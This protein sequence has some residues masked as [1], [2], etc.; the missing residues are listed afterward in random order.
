MS[1]SSTCWSMCAE[2]RYSSP[3]ASMGET[4]A[5]S[6]A[7]V[8]PAK[9][10]ACSAA[11]APR[12]IGAPHLE[13]AADV[14]EHE[15]G[16]RGEDGRVGQ[17]V[18]PRVLHRHGIVA[19]RCPRVADGPR[20]SAD[21]RGSAAS[22]SRGAGRSLRSAACW[23]GC[24]RRR[25]AGPAR[26]SRGAATRSAQAA[27]PSLHR[28]A[29]EPVIL[30]GVPVW[31][32]LAYSGPARDLVRALKFRGAI[33]LA[34]AM[35]AQIVANARAATVLDGRHAR[36]RPVT[37][38]PT[39]LARLQPGGGDRGRGRRPRGTAGARLPLPV[40]P[41]HHPG[42]PRPR[43]TEGRAGRCGSSVDGERPRAGAPRRRRRHDG[44]HSRAPAVTLSSR[45]VRERWWRC[46]SR[47]R[48][49]AEA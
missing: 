44:R 30:C 39:A 14:D 11:R 18:N 29:A 36:S 24:S 5:A 13:E 23:A 2:K 3:S 47:G 40:G 48:S 27:A 15:Q 26:A 9:A 19:M 6:R 12:P 34:D 10:S 8:A 25:S 38:A 22:G 20:S 46:A 17:P 21:G 32:P 42:R 45:P 49:G 28:L 35:A 7:R 1:P 4:S 41:L 16:D 37:S 33:A 31:A 43:R